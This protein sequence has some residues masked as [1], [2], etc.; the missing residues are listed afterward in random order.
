L[1]SSELNRQR[2]QNAISTKAETS[3]YETWAL[4]D[5]SF[6]EADNTSTS[7]RFQLGQTREYLSYLGVRP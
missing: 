6:T 3:T 1:R 7:T 2:W 5:A 4:A